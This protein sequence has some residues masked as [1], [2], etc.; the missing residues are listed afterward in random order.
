MKWLT[1]I[2]LIVALALAGGWLF[3]ADIATALFARGAASAMNADVIGALPDGLH[4]VLCGA[5][6]PLP[7][8][9]RS[10]PCLGVIAGD[11]LVVVDAGS[12]GARNLQAMGISP[13]RVEAVFVTHF[14]S[15]HIDGLGELA[16]LRWT[17]GGRDAP[18]PV[19]APRGIERV[20]DGFNRAYA[21]DFYY[22]V[23]HHGR[24]VLPPSGAGAVAHSFTLPAAGAPEVVWERDGLTVTAF[25]VAHHPIEPA[26][27][28]RFDYRGRSLVVSGDTSSIDELIEISRDVDLLAHEALAAHLVAILENAARDSGQER[29][30]HILND[31]PDYHT[32]PVEAARIASA[33]G[34]GGLLLYHIVPALPLPGLETAFLRGVREVYRGRV[35]VGRDG[36]FVSL[37]ADSTQIRYARLM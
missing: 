7:D 32:T 22:R 34:V 8:R 17:S 30:A 11:V 13:G 37:P 3:R 25:R 21:Q 27:G 2:V 33:A 5:G 23:A 20:V 28:Y 4:V 16:M 29:L 36:T 26:V 35:T 1:G 14:H 12:N 31:I 15:D 18:L 19:H 9:V 24:E 10:G 6:S